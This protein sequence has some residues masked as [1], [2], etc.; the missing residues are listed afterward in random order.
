MPEAELPTYEQ[1][2]ASWLEDV[3]ASNP[4]PLEKGRRFARKLMADW[5][6]LD[7]DSVEIVYCDGT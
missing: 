7:Q 3:L 6:D 4:S 2:C 5:M 1:F